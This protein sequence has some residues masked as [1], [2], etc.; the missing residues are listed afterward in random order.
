VTIV[1][2]SKEEDV[3]SRMKSEKED[4]SK[5]E[6]GKNYLGSIGSY[7]NWGEGGQKELPSMR[8]VFPLR[9]TVVAHDT[10]KN[11]WG[12]LKRRMKERGGKI[13]GVPRKTSGCDH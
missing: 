4:N 13:G 5:K 11:V 7:E 10:R 8:I 6:E 9:I 1:K 2:G 12:P 3:L